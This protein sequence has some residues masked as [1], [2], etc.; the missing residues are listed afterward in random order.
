M[1]AVEN[2]RMLTVPFGFDDQ[3]GVCSVFPLKIVRHLQQDHGDLE[4]PLIG[5]VRQGEHE[6][7]RCQRISALGSLRF[8]TVN[9]L[10]VSATTR[11][12]AL[13]P[14]VKRR[15]DGTRL[16]IDGSVA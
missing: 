15:S 4:P 14:I 1:R 11:S 13:S 10:S 16:L 7:A 8:S 5:P 6:I 9:A 2:M 12:C 3:V